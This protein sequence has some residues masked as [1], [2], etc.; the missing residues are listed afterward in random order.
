MWLIVLNVQSDRIRW[1]SL[2][3]DKHECGK[4]QLSI[5]S[6]MTSDENNHIKVLIVPDELKF[7]NLV[8]E[9]QLS[10]FSFFL[11]DIQFSFC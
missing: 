10:S 11:F 4:I 6:T 9:I 7:N 8:Y 2:Y 3:Q 5:G 1:W